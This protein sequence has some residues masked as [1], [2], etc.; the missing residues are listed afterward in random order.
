MYNRIPLFPLELVIFPDSKYPLY[1]FEERYK[2]LIGECLKNN[3]GF[4]I[5]SIINDKI[6]AIGTIVKV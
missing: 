2:I 5:S 6:S 4:I 1:I 3:S